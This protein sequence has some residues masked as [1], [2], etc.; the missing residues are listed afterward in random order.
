MKTNIL[1]YA[2]SAIVL[3][4]SCGNN[5][6]DADKEA[7]ASYPAQTN[8][9]GNKGKTGFKHNCATCHGS[10]GTAGI[11]NAANLKVSRIDSVSIV[12][13]ISKGKNAMPAFGS[14]LTQEEVA[15]ITSYII[16]LRE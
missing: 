2:L 9:T 12:S 7:S 14:Q 11:G 13:I 1:I 4:S 8:T 6:P 3:S 15:A 16:T 5:D 10:D